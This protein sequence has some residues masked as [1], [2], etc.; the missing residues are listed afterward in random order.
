MSSTVSPLAGKRA[1]VTAAGQG[2]G[3][4]VV[5]AFHASGA[6]V[7]ATDLKPD[8]LVG[9]QCPTAR[10]DVCEH[11][12]IDA[13]FGSFGQLDIL[14]NCVGYVHQGTL[15]E[16]DD[17]A[18]TRTFELNVRSM[19]FTM[20]AAVPLM[21]HA[22]GSIINVASVVSSLKAARARFAYAASKAAVLGMTRS[23]ALD[24]AADRIRANA[25][26]PGTVDTPSLQERIARS[27]DAARARANLI[28]RQPLGRLGTPQEIAQLAL[29]LAS[30]AGAFA[31][32]SA[33]V[34]DGG[35]SA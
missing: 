18:W 5:E 13:L 17:D 33:F 30:D 10:L 9:L 1:I 25:I 21:R 6:H 26:C 27:D 35:M 14:V 22:G 29:Y 3:R 32:G 15:L 34:V 4:A 24:Y 19:F 28:G 8:L 2:I 20:K 23:V 31:S 12:A 7:L 16:T 11:D